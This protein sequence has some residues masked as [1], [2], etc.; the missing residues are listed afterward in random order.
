MAS[1]KV[2]VAIVGAGY[3][4]GPHIEALSAMP[5]VTVR[6]VCDINVGRA[7]R[8]AEAAGIPAAYGSLRELLKSGSTDVVHVLTPPHLHVDP[9]EE[10]LKAGADVLVEKPLAHSVE[11]CQ[12]LRRVAAEE[13]RTLGVSYNFLYYDAYE[14]LIA[15]L[16]SGRLGKLDHVDIVW[17]KH[18]GQL[19]GGPLGAWVFQAPQ[20]I[21]FEV[22][23]HLFAHCHHL[24]GPVGEL[25]VRPFDEI[26][27]PNG[28]T[29]FRRWEILGVA[30]SASV[31][32]RLS[33]ID[34]YPEHYIHIR[35]S[36]AAATVDFERSAYVMSEHSPH[37][38]DVDRYLD[39]TS[40][41][42]QSIAQATGV[43]ARFV[44]SKAGVGQ[45]PGGTYENSI[46]RAI[47]AFYDSRGGVV[48][49]G[50]SPEIGEAAIAL[51]E[52]VAGLVDVPQRDSP[53]A[54]APDVVSKKRVSGPPTVLVIGGTGFIGRALV[55]Q[56]LKGGHSVRVLARNPGA[57]AELADMGVELVKGDF[58][59]LHSVDSALRGIESV[60][61]LARGYGNTWPEYEKYDVE[62]TRRVA[63]LCIEHGVKRLYYAS[64]I[65]IYDAGHR[66]KSIRE[67]TAPVPAMLRAN[68][69]SR[70]KAENEALLLELHRAR[71]LPVVIFR[72]GIVLGPG[73]SPYHWGVA[74]W[75]YS[76]VARLYGDGNN[77]LPIVLVDDVADAMVRG[78][79]TPG[80]EGESFNL[81]AEPC[82]TANEYLDELERHAGIKVRRV[83]TAPW[84]SYGEAV[85]KWAIKSMARNGTSARPSYSNS[86]GQTF[87]STFDA[88]KSRETLGWEPTDSRQ[89][90][91]KHGIHEAIDD[92][93]FDSQT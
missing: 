9:A 13:G 74:A 69:Y 85:V 15:D 4:A 32:M 80:I 37:L 48:D 34:G 40:S 36:N 5:D 59:D 68:P 8:F 70:S 30:G 3:I 83:P 28:M 93:F 77:P 57:A 76:S 90:I 62:P 82:I 16:R 29:F 25:Q 24:V 11:G 19:S 35:G 91:V 64:S 18:L 2:S 51:A 73:G 17:N 41:A 46:A 52:R 60:F 10:A 14:K 21:L 1:G 47:S 50:V 7:E 12:R 79:D 86:R 38:L 54:V 45:L 23:P 22:A 78:M 88:K 66:G 67:S 33:F 84:R 43:L 39:V 75:P 65:A 31:R 61:H 55:R 87:C 27:L 71:G 89:V 26:S 49:E 44:L 53:T 63:E 72:P 20:N 58:S 6:A 56:L 81:T 42:G 92:F